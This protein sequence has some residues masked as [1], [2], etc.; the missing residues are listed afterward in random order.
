MGPE[1]QRGGPTVPPPGMVVLQVVW[2]PLRKLDRCLFSLVLRSLDGL[3][4]SVYF[5]PQPS[6]CLEGS[7][8]PF[9]P[10]GTAALTDGL[11]LW[12]HE[13][14]SWVGS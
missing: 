8:S 2:S 9:F 10:Q 6:E 7:V 12:V 3:G 5:V 13:S 11:C 4:L 1:Q 14:E